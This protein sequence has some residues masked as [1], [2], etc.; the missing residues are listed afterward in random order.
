MMKQTGILQN[1]Y[2]AGFIRIFVGYA[3]LPHKALAGGPYAQCLPT[4]GR[5]FVI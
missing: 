5:P 2:K 4:A 1:L 3:C